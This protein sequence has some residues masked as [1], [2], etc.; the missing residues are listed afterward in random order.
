MDKETLL[1]LIQKE[2]PSQRIV[3]VIDF[4]DSKS[5]IEGVLYDVDVLC[6]HTFRYDSTLTRK[7][8]D[9]PYP[10][11]PFRKHCIKKINDMMEDSKPVF[12]EVNKIINKKN[13]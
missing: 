9:L 13:D 6:E 1:N 12:E 7:H 3:E 2:R 11:E 10:I 5:G 8:T 4:R